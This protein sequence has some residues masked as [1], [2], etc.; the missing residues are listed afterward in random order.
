MRKVAT[1]SIW[2]YQA[3]HANR[4]RSGLVIKKIKLKKLKR[5]Q[6]RHVYLSNN[7]DTNV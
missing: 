4:V 1:T 2:I 7:M 3:S 6:S 5:K